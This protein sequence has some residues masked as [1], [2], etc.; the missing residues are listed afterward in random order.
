MNDVNCILKMMNCILKMVNCP[1]NSGDG[2]RAGGVRVAVGGT[3]P[4]IEKLVET[5]AVAPEG[6]EQVKELKR[7]ERCSSYLPLLL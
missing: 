3:D 2:Q 5:D 7:C 6:K 1:F 4:V